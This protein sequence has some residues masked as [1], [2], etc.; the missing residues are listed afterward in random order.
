MRSRPAIGR[1]PAAILVGAVAALG[2]ATGVGT[3]AAAAPR[4][5]AALPPIRPM[6]SCAGSGQPGGQVTQATV[7]ARAQVWA[8]QNIPY[9]QAC[10]ND[11]G[12]YYREDCSGF[13]S[14]AWELSTSLITTEFNPSYNGG[15]SRFRTISRSALV[16]GDAL[17]RDDTGDPGDSAE[18]HIVLFVG[19]GSA[20]GGAH[21]YADIQEE[22][23]F[24][25]G[26]IADNN[27][28]LV[29]NSF[30]NLFTS[31]HYV[32]LVAAQPRVGVLTSDHHALVKEG[33]L[34]AAWTTENSGVDQVVVSGNRIGVV[35]TGGSAYVK[36]GGLSAPWT[37]ELDGVSQLV[38]S[39]NRIGVV[40]TGGSAYVKEGDLSTPWVHELDG[41]R[42]L[43]LSGTRVGIINTASQAYVKEGA[44]SASWVHEVDSVEELS[45][46]GNRVGVLTTAAQAYVKEGDLSATWVHELDGVKEIVLG[47][48]R[49][50]II[51]TA[52]QA[53]VKEGALSASWVH[54]AD[55]VAHL[56]LT[57]SRVG[58][59]T[60]AASA[61]VKEGALTTAW[62]HQYDGAVQIALT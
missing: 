29:G 17:V 62:V 51:N 4:T 23:T 22:S 13:I 38:L 59:V 50:G 31:I 10:A 42:Q 12:G 35:T 52:S 15:D 36:E 43:A 41:V 21:R 14:M 53:Y 45:L 56:A 1:W 61:Y 11:P 18:H 25:V 27:V 47:G 16:P 7:L 19:W 5:A 24:G 34:T 54:E 8:N 33:A 32:N 46:A 48:N 2:V 9:T 55:G 3:P 30:W 6:S 49:V 57:G 28:D 39:G 37:H 40:T 26:T 60:T 20:D 58:I 44:L